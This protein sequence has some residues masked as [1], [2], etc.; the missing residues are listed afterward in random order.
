MLL[1]T[2]LE[3]LLTAPGGRIVVVGSTAARNGAASAA[4]GAAKAA[5]EG[6]ILTLAARL[7]PQ[8]ITANVVAPGFTSDT[9]LT[10]GRMPPE[11]LVRIVAAI[12]AG[13]PG[14]AAEIASVIAFLAGPGG[15]YV[16]GQVIAVDG[17][18]AV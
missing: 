17:G 18:H 2:A 6:W 4:Y 5:L 13:R 12:A 9:E 11:R 1:T 16:N 8:G 7:G 15:A 3:D 10:A 14:S